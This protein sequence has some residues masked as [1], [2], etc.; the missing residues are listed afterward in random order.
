MGQS[1]SISIFKWCTDWM[2]QVNLAFSS[3]KVDVSILN[4]EGKWKVSLFM[5]LY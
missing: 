3:K 4:R 2:N 5:V 1:N